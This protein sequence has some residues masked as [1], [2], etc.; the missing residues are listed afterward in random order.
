LFDALAMRIRT[1]GIVAALVAASQ[2]SGDAFAPRKTAERP[3]VAA[4]RAPRTLRATTWTQPSRARLLM[5]ALPGWRAIWDADTDVPLRLVGPSLPAP[6]S[7]IDPA[8]AERAA[9][10][11]LAAQLALL[12]P[13]ARA[14]DFVL[15]ANVV[16][17]SGVRTVGFEQHANG[18]RV[19]GGTI[20][21]AFAHDRLMAVSSTALPDVAARM[22]G[23]ALP[24]PTIDRAAIDW[25]AIAKH[26]VAVRARGDRSILPLVHT[27]RGAVDI[28]YR[29]VEQV[30]VETTA[31]E[32]GRWDV[33]L[34]A[35][36]AAPIARRQT[37]AFASGVV[38]FNVPDR[39]PMST[40]GP[41]PAPFAND[42]VDGAATTSAADG[43]VTWTQAG[44]ATVVPGLA[45]T[46]AAIT[47]KSG[48]LVT[49][50]LTL[51]PE[52]TVTWDQ[53]TNEQ[54]D[55][56]L[57]AYVYENTLKQFVLANI[58]P[59]LGWAKKQESVNV[60]ESMTCNAYS[61]G[62]DIHFYVSKPGMC[63]N[64]GRIADVIYHESGHSVHNNSVIPGQ[65][66]FEPALSEGLA[67]TMAVSITGDHGVGRGFFLND[68]PLRDVQQDPPRRWPQDVSGEP[69]ND[70]EIIAGAL[71]DLR[72]ALQTKLGQD[73]GYKQ[74]LKVYYGVVQRSADI[75]STYHEALIADDDDGNLANGTPNSCEIDAAFGRHGLADPTMTIGLT[76]PVRSDYTVTFSVSPPNSSC[77][78]PTVQSATLAWNPR[79]GT[80]G[81]VPATAAGNTWTATI[82]T[83]PD[84]TVVEYA[85][86]ITL[87]DGSTFSYPDNAADPKY[88]FYVGPTTMIWCEDFETGAPG[89][90][91]GGSPAANDEWQIGAPAGHGGDPTSAHG[92][93]NAFG[94]DLGI[95]GDADGLYASN[96]M[97]YAESPAID[98]KG[99]THV[100]LQYW[101]WLGVEDGAYDQGKIS[102][103]GTVVWS[104]LAS[105]G[106]PMN[107]VNH[108]DKE[109]RFQDVDL[110]AQAASG[111]ITLRFELDSDPGLELGGWTI[112]DVCIVAV[113][114]VGPTCG[115]GVVEAGEQCDDGAQNGAPGDPCSATCT[116]AGETHHHGGCCDAGGGPGG[117]I[118]L[119]FGTLG[120]ALGR[121]RRPR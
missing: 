44:N 29:V 87:S 77:A 9:R 121:R 2:H 85:V 30:S 1:V 25:L 116:L 71:W 54:A 21:F 5:P 107:E 72:V 73:A 38:E 59:N 23:G 42:T 35:A 115:D 113:P 64:T 41:K 75:P 92:G 51:A 55:A 111:K 19:V 84:G 110:T 81:T 79:G 8:A 53:S 117:A 95:S 114:A 65:G 16:G 93:A 40:R 34:D 97:Q 56:Q 57:D 32:A 78:L 120:L 13:G 20:G 52:G 109:W 49:T 108:V 96:T 7:S 68:M 47:N 50:S 98:L 76:A 91:H 69:H 103:N 45:G 31:G 61:T 70:G 12:A 26:S 66:V 10:A 28:E 105:P 104:N 24:A 4:G 48:S 86:T 46:F 83:Q 15:V 106:M 118:V 88:Q 3:I 14:T 94:I 102:A 18:L 82:P 33:W 27:R 11:F 80:G 89:W 74:F 90:T 22:P 67:D 63:E 37:L 62:D 112:D 36:D 119:A 100:H 58:N 43:T 39:Y 101:R 6:G 60:N 99:H 17:P